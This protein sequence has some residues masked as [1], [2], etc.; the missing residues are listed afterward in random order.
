M[1][2]VSADKG[3]PKGKPILEIC[4]DNAEGLFAAIEGGADRVELCS[5]L[6]VGGLTPSR[7]FMTL[8]GRQAVSVY[9]M[10]RPRA[11]SF[12]F[13]PEEVEM[14]KTDIDAARAAGLNGV[15]LGATLADGCLDKAVLSTLCRHARGLDLSLHRAFDITPNQLEALETA[16]E[17][18]FS[19]I[20][21][22]GGQPTAL[23]GIE[24]LDQLV[25]SANDRISIMPGS[26]VRPE[27]VQA[28]LHRLAVHELHA[29]CSTQFTQEDSQLVEL[30][31]AKRTMLRTDA[32]I[33]RAL[34][35]QLCKAVSARISQMM[36]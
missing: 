18:G 17:L 11:G 10:I 27:N 5:A 29:S 6:P 23:L 33:V 28:F 35:D 13:T 16:I 32:T 30:N 25:K 8:A 19:R 14:M 15:V 24:T 4:V 20:L 9:A 7:G 22:S 34:K 1:N 2:H 3:N 31:F 21:T 12:V 36:T 26:G